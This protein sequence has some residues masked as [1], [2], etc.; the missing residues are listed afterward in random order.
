M[1]SSDITAML[2]ILSRRQCRCRPLACLSPEASGKQRRTVSPSPRTVRALRNDGAPNPPPNA[3]GRS[4]RSSATGRA[5]ERTPPLPAA[6]RAGGWSLCSSTSPPLLSQPSSHSK[7][8][9]Q[10]PG[11]QAQGATNEPPAI[12]GGSSRAP[13]SPHR[14]TGHAASPSPSSSGR[15]LDSQAAAAWGQGVMTAQ[16]SA[17]AGASGQVI[18][19]QSKAMPGR[20]LQRQDAQTN[21]KRLPR[22]L[23]VVSTLLCHCYSRSGAAGYYGSYKWCNRC[24]GPTRGHGLRRVI[25][26]LRGS[27]GGVHLKPEV[28]DEIWKGEFIELYSLLPREDFIDVDEEKDK[29][30]AKKRE[31]EE[32]KR[33]RKIPKTFGTWLMAFCIYA[34]VLGEKQP[35]LCSSHFCY[36]DEIW[37]ASRDFGG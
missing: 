33:Y 4:V 15:S 31:E 2:E 27:P 36:V 8:T 26:L 25:L 20:T 7:S 18:I 34:G 24:G 23:R 1:A 35:Q 14:Q 3:A 17:H 29:E 12:P 13:L 19:L 28:K 9:S 6:A 5:G 30:K 10:G 37:S 22:L 32:K 11:G 16:N 21:G